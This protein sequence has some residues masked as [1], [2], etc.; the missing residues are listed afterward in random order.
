MRMRHIV[1]YGLS[2]ST[3]FLHIISKNDTIFGTKNT[4]HKMCVMIFFT[5]LSEI[6]L[7][8]RRNERDMVIK[9]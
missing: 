2:G 4:E 8:L 7:S 6:F 5:I 1:T 9:V 3:I